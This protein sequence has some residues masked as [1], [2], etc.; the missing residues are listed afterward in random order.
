AFGP[1]VS[2]D[3]QPLRGLASLAIARRLHANG[4]VTPEMREAE[5]ASRRA[6]VALQERVR[7]LE[8]EMA[9]LGAESAAR[10]ATLAA[11]QREAEVLRQQAEE[12]TTQ[13]Q[14][15]G[16]Q[17]ADRAEALEEQAAAAG[18]HLSD[19]FAKLAE[20]QG[21][22]DEMGSTLEIVREAFDVIAHDPDSG[23]FTRAFVAWFC[24]RFQAGRCSLMRVDHE[25]GDLRILAHQGMDATL[26]SRVRVR[27]GQGVSG[28]V[29][30]HGQPVLMR[31]GAEATPVRPTGLDRYNSDSFMSLPLVHRRRV[32]GVLNLSNKHA[33]EPFDA[34]DLDRAQLA[35]HVLAMALGGARE[36]VA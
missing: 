17:H 26:A 30:H 25:A 2:E 12:A 20:T 24:D 33:G 16:Q 19:A 29:A 13:G 7:E 27:V 5:L 35:S 9:R 21:R 28:W 3:L 14:H 15:L 10:R 8:T 23:S 11:T 6:T 18:M 22:L 32:V 4:R 34:L 1:A 36:K 31:D